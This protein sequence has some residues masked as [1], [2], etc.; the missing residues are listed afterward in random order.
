LYPL[1]AACLHITRFSAENYS[2]RFLKRLI[3]ADI[4]L[5]VYAMEVLI[6]CLGLL[7][8]ATPPRR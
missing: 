6:C 1:G 5:S 4:S 7:W 8:T 2:F 3:S